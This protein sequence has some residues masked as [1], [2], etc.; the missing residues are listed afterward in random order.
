M[1][2]LFRHRMSVKIYGQ[3]VVHSVDNRHRHGDF[4]NWVS[5]IYIRVRYK[6]IEDRAIGT[7]TQGQDSC[8]YLGNVRTPMIDCNADRK[9]VVKTRK[10]KS[11]LQRMFANHLGGNVAFVAP[12]AFADV[13]TSEE[14]R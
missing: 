14:R 7:R 5:R 2:N 8:H 10:M 3:R 12:G 11:A 9:Y 1:R 13:S 4:F 6:H